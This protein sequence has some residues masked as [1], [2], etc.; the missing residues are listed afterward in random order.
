MGLLISGRGRLL[1]AV[2]LGTTAAAG[3]WLG[4]PAAGADATWVGSDDNW[5]SGIN[6]STGTTPSGG[7]VATFD[8]APSTSVTIDTPATSIG[9]MQFS[10]TAD[11][12]LFSINNNF[13]VTG[14]GILNG[15]SN[16]QVFLIFGALSFTGGTTTGAVEL[17]NFGALSYANA[18]AGS[19]SIFNNS[20]STSTPGRARAMQPSST[21]AP[22]PSISTAQARPETPPSPI[23]ASPTSISTATAKPARRISTISAAS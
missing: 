7:N 8:T 15:S 16:A 2:L 1:R 18:S 13:A 20:T 10:P 5:N 22:P 6:W 11:T 19:A 17:D 12:H 23:T 9:T 21:T 4:G 14:G 3:L